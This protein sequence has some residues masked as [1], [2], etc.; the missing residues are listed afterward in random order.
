V[1]PPTLRRGP[2]LSRSN[3]EAR[4]FLELLRPL[5]GQLEAYCRRMLRDRSEV[6]DVLQASVARAFARFDR[7]SQGTN[8]KAWM[9]RFVTLEILNRNRKRRP[10]SFAELPADLPA[11]ESWGLVDMDGT[12]AAMLEDPDVVL[13][14]FEDA[15]VEAL[16][17]LAPLERATLLLRSIGEFNYTE[18][19]DILAIPLGSVIGYLSRA[20]QK[21]R[22]SLAD[23]A[24]QRGPYRPGPLPGGPRP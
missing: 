14:H 3:D 13:D 20:R 24:A 22:L 11:E 1:A 16:R 2:T 6:E 15:V 5:Q 17:R 18:I 9:F 12:F 10:V 21:L 8:F 4:S 19:H 7:Y 23:Y